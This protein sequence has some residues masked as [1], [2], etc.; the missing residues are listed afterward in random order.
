MCLLSIQEDEVS[1]ESSSSGTLVGSGPHQSQPTCIAIRKSEQERCRS[2]SGELTLSKL[3]RDTRNI[4]SPTFPDGSFE[5]ERVPMSVLTSCELDGNIRCP[6]APEQDMAR[7]GDGSFELERVPS[8]SMPMLA[9]NRDTRSPTAPERDTTR[10]GVNLERVKDRKDAYSTA[11]S[12]LYSDANGQKDSAHS[13]TKGGACSNEEDSAN[14]IS[15]L[16]KKRDVA[17]PTNPSPLCREKTTSSVANDVLNTFGMSRKK[18][19]EVER[20]SKVIAQVMTENKLTQ[21]CLFVS[22][23][24]V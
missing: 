4:R 8:M 5:L 14:T 3:D 12:A 1:L 10:N 11:M 20:F 16:G 6:N 7:D 2:L 13:I 15:L 24:Y 22:K 17:H 21:V 9:C 18:S 19:H 23:G